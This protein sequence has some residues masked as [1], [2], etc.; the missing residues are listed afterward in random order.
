MSSDVKFPSSSAHAAKKLGI[1]TNPI[2]V[3]NRMNVFLLK[4]GN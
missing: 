2:T 4:S 3:V 1:N